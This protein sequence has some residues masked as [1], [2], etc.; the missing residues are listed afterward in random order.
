MQAFINKAMLSLGLDDATVRGATGCVLRMA[1]LGL[2]EAEYRGLVD[3][4]RNGHR[5]VRD[6][7]VPLETLHEALEAATQRL[8]EAQLSERQVHVFVQM[9]LD[10]LVLRKGAPAVERLLR[11]VEALQKFRKAQS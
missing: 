10:H 7:P 6:L 11:S 1:Q 8:A 5:M 4:L 2:P 3:G 9:L